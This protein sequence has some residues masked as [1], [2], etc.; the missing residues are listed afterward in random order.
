MHAA[1]EE[2]RKRKHERD[3][4]LAVRPVLHWTP[5]VFDA[6]GIKARGGVKDLQRCGRN[7]AVEYE[8]VRMASAR[9]HLKA[10]ML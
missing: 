6:G 7:Y 2:V 8:I 10:Y 3:T 5:P 1:G 4:T 9:R